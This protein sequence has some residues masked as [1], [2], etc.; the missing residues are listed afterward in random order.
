[1]Q[2]H[3]D[4]VHLWVNLLLHVIILVLDLRCDGSLAIL[5]VHGLYHA[6]DGALAVFEVVAVVVADDIAHRSIFYVTLHTQ[7]MEES[8]VTL[9]GLRT[10]VLW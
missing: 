1:M 8:L 6:L 9:G 5:R 4:Y 7:Q 10:F 3:V 2:H